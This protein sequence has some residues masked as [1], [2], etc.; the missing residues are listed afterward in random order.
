MKSVWNQSQIT[1]NCTQ[2]TWKFVPSYYTWRDKRRYVNGHVGRTWTEL[3]NMIYSQVKMS[4][5]Y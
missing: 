4:V 5:N 3:N 2:K 1:D